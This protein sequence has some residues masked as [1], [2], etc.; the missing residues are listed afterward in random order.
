MVLLIDLI[1]EQEYVLQCKVDGITNA[2]TDF[3]IFVLFLFWPRKWWLGSAYR[4]IMA[5]GS[6]ELWNFCLQ[7]EFMWACKCQNW[8]VH[9]ICTLQS[10]SAASF[11]LLCTWMGVNILDCVLA[12]RSEPSVWSPSSSSI[13]RTPLLRNSLPMFL[14]LSCPTMPR[15][16]I[17]V[18]ACVCVCVWAGRCVCVCMWK[19]ERMGE[20]ERELVYYTNTSR[21]FGVC[22]FCRRFFLIVRKADGTS[23]IHL[24]VFVIVFSHDW[25]KT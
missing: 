18:C 7:V 3:L 10:S 11:C 5:K 21:F 14:L 25:T 23:R 19:K 16:S 9:S 2:G 1:I 4:L 22:V 8:L 15:V 12:M 17:C 24:F 13:L 6:L 20:R